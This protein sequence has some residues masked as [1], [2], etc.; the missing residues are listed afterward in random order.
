M[1]KQ[2]GSIYILAL[3]LF[4]LIAAGVLYWYTG[5][6]S[7]APTNTQAGAPAVSDSKETKDPNSGY[8]LIKEFGVRFKLPDGVN[9]LLYEIREFE[10]ESMAGK[11][12]K[13]ADLSSQALIDA[14]AKAGAA[15]NQC[16][17]DFAPL[18]TI[19]RYQKGELVRDVPIEQAGAVVVGDYYYLFTSPQAACSGDAGVND[20]A[21]TQLKAV[22]KAIAGLEPAQ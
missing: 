18:G 20:L 15:I 9:E 21:T 11:M 16:S 6:D 5:R 8:L 10:S 12:I 2:S 17:A 1:R 7:K 4:A 13:T 14:E 3:V 22:S 19:S